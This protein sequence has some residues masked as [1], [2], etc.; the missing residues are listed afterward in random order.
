L[1]EHPLR[2]A[3]FETWVAS[4]ILKSR[5]HRGLQL[6]LSFYRDRKGAEVDLAV[7]LGRSVL[8]VETKSGQTVAADYFT[9]L[10]AFVAAAADRLSVRS[11]AS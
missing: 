11:R 7:E 10:K 8:A 4:E 2:G 5:L 1:R 6:S 3:V 9:G